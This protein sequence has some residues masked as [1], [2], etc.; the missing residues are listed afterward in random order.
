MQR[1]GSSQRQTCALLQLSRTVYLYESAARD[2]S[3]LAVRI[4]EIPEVRVHYGAPCV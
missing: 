2:Q 3:A 1:F 4:K